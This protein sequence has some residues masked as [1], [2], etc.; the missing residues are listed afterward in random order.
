MQSLR[1]RGKCMRVQIDAAR[2]AVPDHTKTTGHA[3]RHDTVRQLRQRDTIAC[4]FRRPVGSGRPW[5]PRHTSKAASRVTMSTPNLLYKTGR[6]AP[7]SVFSCALCGQLLGCVGANFRLPL[8]P[9]F[10]AAAFRIYKMHL[11]ASRTQLASGKAVGTAGRV[12]E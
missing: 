2:T 3:V 5:T 6:A 1:S 11:V 10:H 8:L 12:G 4:C 9:L 7:R